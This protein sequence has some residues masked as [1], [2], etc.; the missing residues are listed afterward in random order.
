[1]TQVALNSGYI[2]LNGLWASC[3]WLKLIPAVFVSIYLDHWRPAVKGML[4]WGNIIKGLIYG[5]VLIVLWNTA[6]LAIW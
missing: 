6:M 1:M 3:V 4:Y 5:M 2:E